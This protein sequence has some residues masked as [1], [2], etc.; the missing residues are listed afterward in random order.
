MESENVKKF[1]NY[2]VIAN[3]SSVF[4]IYNPFHITFKICSRLERV[5]AHQGVEKYV[6][7]DWVFFRKNKLGSY[8]QRK[9]SSAGNVVNVKYKPGLDGP[10][11]S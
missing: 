6:G 1:K 2:K 11:P 7:L 10:Q 5:A 3:L 8:S 9:N 4:Y